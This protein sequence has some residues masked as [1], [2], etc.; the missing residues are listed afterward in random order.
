MT[1][2]TNGCN[3]IISIEPVII[4]EPTVIEKAS[5]NS[6]FTLVGING[7][8]GFGNWK[9]QFKGIIN[10][11]QRPLDKQFPL[12]GSGSYGARGSPAIS[13]FLGNLQIDVTYPPNAPL[14]TRPSTT[15][16]W[17]GTITLTG[18]SLIGNLSRQ[19]CDVT[20]SLYNVKGSYSLKVTNGTSLITV[21]NMTIF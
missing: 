7:I 16:N 18:G 8:T 1:T 20:P 17:K 15:T 13:S 10:E 4:L 11:L 3:Q 2:L 14:P 9:A 19:E 12:L 21:K 5:Y 6:Q